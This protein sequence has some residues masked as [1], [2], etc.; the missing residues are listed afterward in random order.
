LSEIRRSVKIRCSGEFLRC[1]ACGQVARQGHDFASI[2]AEEPAAQARHL[3]KSA[4]FAAV[5]S[6][7]GPFAP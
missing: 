4:V 2:L 7:Y 1:S 5:T 6:K 3:A